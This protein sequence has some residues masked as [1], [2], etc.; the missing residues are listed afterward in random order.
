MEATGRPD[1]AA[2]TASE[3]A[4]ELRGAGLVRLVAAPDGDALAAAGVLARTL[5]AD[6]AAFH[7]SVAPG[8]PATD[9]STDADLTVTVGHPGGDLALLE[10]PVSA[11][12][13]QVADAVGVAD[14]T[15]ALA[16]VVAGGADPGQFDAPMAAAD[17]DRRPGLAVPVAD[18]ADGL[19]HT[20]LVH[21]R[22][23][24]DREAAGA[25]LADVGLDPDG[26]PEDEAGREDG[27]TAE[28]VA[29]AVAV[30][31]VRDAPRRAAHAVERV[32]RPH[33]VASDFGT[34][35][36]LADVLDATARTAPGT[37]VALA[38]GHDAHESG[39]AAWREHGVAAHRAVAAAETAR[40]DGVTV[41]HVGDGP[42]GTVARLV[43]DFRSR[44]PVAV[45][46]GE[47][48]VAVAGTEDVQEPL[49]GAADAVDAPVV[50]RASRGRVADVDPAAFVRAFREAI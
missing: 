28:R 9:R 10:D 37:G 31:T 24:G 12:A 22:F 15:L 49:R 48:A 38:L 2:P 34:L 35:G 33:A 3:A 1:G 50:G 17:L 19:A 32:L 36:G 39:L 8:P 13:Y 6:G 27:S 26:D 11:A 25:L 41:A 40:H 21:G 7:V 4:A 47:D 23:S 20:G 44:E 30:E 45:A 18:L 16:G 46:A 43:R 5:A 14:P 29:S 42:L